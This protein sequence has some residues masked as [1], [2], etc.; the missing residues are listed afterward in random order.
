MNDER[1]DVIVLYDEEGN[2]IPFEH[3][4]TFELDSKT[5]VVLLEVIEGEENDE[6]AIFRVANN[7]GE[8]TLEV[9]E[10]DEELAAAFGE[11]QFRIEDNLSDVEE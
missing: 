8:E 6:V 5:Y 11:F 9:I 1:D 7:N 3:L 4:D 10:D 2:E